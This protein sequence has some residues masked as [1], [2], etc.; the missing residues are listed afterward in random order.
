MASKEN[1]ERIS[2]SEKF[3]GSAAKGML[4]QL[5]LARLMGGGGGGGRT[6]NASDYYNDETLHRRKTEANTQ[7]RKDVITHQTNERIRLSRELA[8]DRAKKQKAGSKSSTKNQPA[9]KAPV[10]KK[11][12]TKSSTKTTATK[13]PAAKP[14]AKKTAVGGYGTSMKSGKQQQS[15]IGYDLNTPV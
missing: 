11:T 7:S 1:M 13:K 3:S 10:A 5:F 6:R 15:G 12:T 2:K 8:K 14:A 9:K 4:N